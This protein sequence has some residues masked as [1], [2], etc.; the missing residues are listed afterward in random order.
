MY[1][2]LSACI[3]PG[4]STSNYSSMFN[5]LW[6]INVFKYHCASGKHDGGRH[7]ISIPVCMCTYQVFFCWLTLN[8]CVWNEI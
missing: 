8:L 3:I 5:N 4:K 2:T 7:S 6:D 1:V